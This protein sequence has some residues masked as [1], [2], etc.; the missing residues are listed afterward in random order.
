LPKFFGKNK[1]LYFNLITFFK[2]SPI[3]NYE[4]SIPFAWKGWQKFAWNKKKT[5]FFAQK[6]K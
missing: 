3:D 2:T 5:P 6:D 1:V 4:K